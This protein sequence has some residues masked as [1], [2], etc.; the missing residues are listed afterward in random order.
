LECFGK[1]D[2]ASGDI[3]DSL[4]AI[5]CVTE[6]SYRSLSSA[7]DLP[8]QPNFAPEKIDSIRPFAMLHGLDGN[9]G[10]IQPEIILWQS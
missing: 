5:L 7:E 3:F 9:F 4:S 2:C 10:D 1:A 6:A 8:K